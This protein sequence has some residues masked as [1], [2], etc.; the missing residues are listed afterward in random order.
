[1]HNLLAGFEPFKANLFENTLRP[2]LHKYGLKKQIFES[3]MAKGKIK[4]YKLIRLDHDIWLV[5]LHIYNL[6]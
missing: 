3:C 6:V 4:F 1:M 5:V 2:E